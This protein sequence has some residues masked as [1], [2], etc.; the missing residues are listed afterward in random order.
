MENQDIDDGADD[1]AHADLPG[2]DMRH[3]VFSRW[4]VSELLLGSIPA[5]EEDDGDAGRHVRGRVLDVAGGKGHL[6]S[7]LA[8]LGVRCALVD[9]C[10]ETGRMLCSSGF[11][12]TGKD[13]EQMSTAG[14]VDVADPLLLHQRLATSASPAILPATLKQLL[15]HVPEAVGGCAAVV[16][17]HPD[18]ATE[19]IVDVALARRAP[20]AVVPC[21]VLPQLFRWRR[22]GSSGAFVRK[23]NAF[24]EYLLE[25]D[26]RIQ[27]A[28]L[29]F[30][31]RSTVLFMTA[32]DYAKKKK[33][34][35]RGRRGGTVYGPEYLPC[36][37]AAKVGDLSRIMALRA[38]GY[39]WNE[40]ATQAAAWSG[41]LE[42]L[43]WMRQ[44]G[45]PWDARLFGAARRG[46]HDHI[47]EWAISQGC[48]ECQ[49]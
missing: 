36:A 11:F 23:Y 8:G 7:A 13:G 10:A 29:P 20:F 35:R 5:P 4:I 47:V 16:G 39:P 27:C 45:C 32:E 46:G 19:E 28:Q 34:R 44:E 15:D 22:L 18:E 30:A 17:L 24:L 31:G 14:A 37:A 26:T 42:A 9:P 21:C 25:K 1:D 12:A 33:K 38:E 41:N 40:E 48:P 2:K 6:S 49:N 43:Q 3:D